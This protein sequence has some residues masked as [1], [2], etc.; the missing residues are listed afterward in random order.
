MGRQVVNYKLLYKMD[1]K[2]V[3]NIRGAISNM[4]KLKEQGGRRG[5]G[6]ALSIY[7]DVHEAI[8]GKKSPLNDNQKKAIHYNLVHHIPQ[9]GVSE[10]MGLSQRTI[11]HHIHQGLKKISEFLMKGEATDEVYSR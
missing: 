5:D 7:I 4:D 1:Y 6:V 3:N 10:I 8:Y 11:S 2:N 9:A